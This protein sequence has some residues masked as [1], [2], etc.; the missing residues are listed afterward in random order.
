MATMCLLVEG[1]QSRRIN[2]QVHMNRHNNAY[3]QT[4]KSLYKQADARADTSVIISNINLK[5][6]QNLY[7]PIHL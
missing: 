6:G 5:A 1:Q 2:K 4:N 7:T 3:E